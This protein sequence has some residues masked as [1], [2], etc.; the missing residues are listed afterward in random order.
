MAVLCLRLLHYER[1]PPPPP[2]HKL[3]TEQQWVLFALQMRGPPR[4]QFN[5]H[6]GH[7]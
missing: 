6:V 5:E 1:T 4:T 2:F 3:L 7:C